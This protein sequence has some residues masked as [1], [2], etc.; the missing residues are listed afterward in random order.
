MKLKEN[1]FTHL[2]EV[3]AQSPSDDLA[4]KRREA[5][6]VAIL[7]DLPTVKNEEWKYTSLRHIANTDFRLHT[8]PAV[9]PAKWLKKLI[10]LQNDYYVICFVNGFLNKELSNL[11]PNDH[12]HIMPIGDG[13][14]NHPAFFLQFFGSLAPD[15]ADFFTSLNTALGKQGLF[16]KLDKGASIDKPIRVVYLQVEDEPQ[17]TLIRN[18]IVLE[19]GAKLSL[20]ED[21]RSDDA[22][23]LLNR[24][25]EIFLAP[26]AR[27]N[28]SLLQIQCANLSAISKT[29]VKQERDSYF[30]SNTMS[31]C[32]KL[33]RNNLEVMHANQNCETHLYGVYL[34]ANSQLIDNH[35]LIDHAS[36]HCNSSEHY[37]GILAHES[38]GVFNGK[39]MVR[40]DAQKTNAFQVNNNIV[41]HDTATMFAKPQLEIFAD[42]VKCSHGATVG[43]LNEQE[44]F[45][46]QAR[47]ISK[48]EAMRLLMEA[49]AGEIILKMDNEKLVQEVL[50]SM[51]QKLAL[52]VN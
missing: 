27:L 19:Q 33:L 3:C 32:G 9:V 47:G 28:R 43:T 39:V 13:F 14:K 17:I 18:L 25:N 15:N 40:P 11:P 45:Y 36:P 34:P 29:Y 20:V 31:W 23:H 1:L 41:L 38:K 8:T 35:T 26:S 46:L 49:F 24:V 44:V 51:Q 21:F 22:T 12:I 6:N 50:Q 10:A 7:Q 16:I 52:M 42:D 2:Q 5:A 4:S 30:E 37:K 48:P